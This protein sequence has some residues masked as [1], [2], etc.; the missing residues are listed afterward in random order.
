MTP[1]LPPKNPPKTLS[2]LADGDARIAARAFENDEAIAYG[3]EDPQTKI[4]RPPACGRFCP[5]GQFCALGFHGYR[6][7][8]PC[9][10]CQRH[11]K[12]PAFPYGLTGMVSRLIRRRP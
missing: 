1:F 10:A 3:F 8:N 4:R 2:A 11:Q 5:T 12:I 9:P 6:L 7:L